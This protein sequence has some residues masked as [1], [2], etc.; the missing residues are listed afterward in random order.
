MLAVLLLR[1]KPRLGWLGWLGSLGHL[2]WFP[3]VSARL[4][5]LFPHLFA[6][7]LVSKP[8]LFFLSLSTPFCLSLGLGFKILPI[9]TQFEYPGK[10]HPSF[11]LFSFFSFSTA[12][13]L[14]ASS[15][16]QCWPRG[17]RNTVASLNR[18]SQLRESVV[19]SRPFLSRPPQTYSYASRSLI[20]STML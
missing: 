3:S 10:P 7:S 17:V 1:T 2:H 16:L 11:C 18:H 20:L 5:S 4:P 12:N 19:E 8:I 15:F 6:H 13:P 9:L 14:T